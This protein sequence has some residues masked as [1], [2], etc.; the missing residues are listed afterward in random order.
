MSYWAYDEEGE[1]IEITPSDFMYQIDSA[2]KEEVQ[3]HLGTHYLH[4]L[5][6]DEVLGKLID[7][8]D[9]EIVM[10]DLIFAQPGDMTEVLG[11]VF[12]SVVESHKN[13][14]EYLKTQVQKL[15]AENREM[16]EKLEKTDIIIDANLVP[17][18]RQALALEDAQFQALP[19]EIRIELRKKMHVLDAPR[20]IEESEVTDLDPDQ[21]RIEVEELM[22]FDTEV[23]LETIEELV[24]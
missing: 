15:E 9:F 18:L 19:Q 11:T 6:Q 13:H 14:A 3:E 20:I 21:V 4:M 24:A 8:T 16:R 2:E 10:N 23:T 5:S 17:T 1:E 7:N 12:G 22:N